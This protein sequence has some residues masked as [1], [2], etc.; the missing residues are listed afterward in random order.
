HKSL[1]VDGANDDYTP[2]GITVKHG[3]LIL[4]GAS[5]EV[6]TG[7]WAGKTDP[8]GHSG[9]CGGSDTDGALMF[10]IGA[11]A[12]HK[13][14]KHKLA[15]AESDGELKLKVRDTKY[16]DNKGSFSVDVIRI[17]GQMR[18]PEPTKVVVDVANDEW[19]PSDLK[20]EKGDLVLVSARVDPSAP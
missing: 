7:A 13:A 9:R 15:V 18:P 4:I 2:T 11:T 10:K 17:P 8:N 3:D 1:S 16:N 5:G 6:V 14:G 19:T 12:P 20:V